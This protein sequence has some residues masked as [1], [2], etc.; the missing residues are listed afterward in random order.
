MIRLD[1]IVS[2]FIKNVDE[3]ELKGIKLEIVKVISKSLVDKGYPQHI[4]IDGDIMSGEIEEVISE[5]EKEIREQE[6][7]EME[8]TLESIKRDMY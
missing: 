3:V 6:D 5:M 7:K 2:V 1:N 4:I 8:E